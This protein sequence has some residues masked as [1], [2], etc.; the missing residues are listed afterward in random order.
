MVRDVIARTRRDVRD[1]SI[2]AAEEFVSVNPH[3]DA[4]IVAAGPVERA[5]LHFWFRSNRISLELD[6][7]YRVETLEGPRPESVDLIVLQVKF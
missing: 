6:D 3:V 4:S 2:F 5:A 7:T 1:V